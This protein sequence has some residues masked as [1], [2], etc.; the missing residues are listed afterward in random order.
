[1]NELNKLA[2]KKA[3]WILQECHIIGSDRIE[4][5][6]KPPFTVTDDM[7]FSTGQSG[8]RY[9]EIPEYD[10]SLVD[11]LT[12]VKDL[13]YFIRYNKNTGIHTVEL[14]DDD[15]ITIVKTGYE[16]QKV[17]LSAWMQYEPKKVAENGS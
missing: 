3:G 13:F 5:Y 11:A 10:N 8:V 6:G 4:W 2:A 17:I 12:L 14:F 1:M 9:L 15:G 7:K 16:L